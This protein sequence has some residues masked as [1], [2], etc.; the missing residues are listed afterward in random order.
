ME[1]PLAA[2]KPNSQVV[3][4][5][6][7]AF[8]AAGPG[9]DALVAKAA[10]TLGRNWRWLRPLANR[11]D[12]RF[13]GLTRPRLQEVVEF[14]EA[15]RGLRAAWRWHGASI[16]VAQRIAGPQPMLPVAA[17]AGWGVPAIESVAELARWLRL[18]ESELEWFA[19]LKNLGRQPRVPEQLRHYHYRMVQKRSGSVRLIESPKQLM[20]AM[21]RQILREILNRIPAHEAAHGFVRGR[22]IRT[23]AEPHAGRASVLR[24]D[25]RDYFPSVRRARVQSIFRTLGYP[26]PVADLLGGI[27]TTRTPREV[28]RAA[29]H[30]NL[31]ELRVLYGQSHL[32]QGAPTSPALANACCYRLD[33]RLAGLA[34]AAGAA[35]TRYADDLAFS[36]DGKFAR[37]VERFA[38]HVGAIVL[39]EGLAVN[40]RKTRIMRQSIQQHLAG[41]VVNE[42]VNVKRADYDRLK[43]ILTNCARNGPEAENRDGRQDFRAHLA[44][45]VAFVGSINAMRAEKLRDLL[46]KVNWD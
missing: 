28:F 12:A 7:R 43:A 8:V 17:A 3:R 30:E 32:P 2:V 42:R 46:D 19:D 21:Q 45:R 38:D 24:L 16:R 22:S 18:D 20:K 4:Y 23:F 14:L 6:A 31:A 1:H 39:E 9:V 13:A 34:K 5:L 15:D 11:Y 25:L 27:A 35:Y 26:E 33:C 29:A 40:Y 36:G 10:E 44:G 41:L 37:G